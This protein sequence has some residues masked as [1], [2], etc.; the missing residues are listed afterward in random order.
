M[1]PEASNF[2]S[3]AGAAS[4]AGCPSGGKRSNNSP[5]ASTPIRVSARDRGDEP[6]GAGDGRGR[7]AGSEDAGGGIYSSWRALY[8]ELRLLEPLL[9]SHGVWQD[10][11]ECRPPARS[12]R[13]PSSPVWD[14]HSP[15]YISASSRCRVDPQK[16]VA[17]AAA[18]AHV[19][20]V[21]RHQQ[22]QLPVDRRCPLDIRYHLL[23]PKVLKA[24]ALT[25]SAKSH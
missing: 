2:R 21:P 15:T 17:A 18:A 10:R 6:R 12:R 5:G 14:S 7:L 8:G 4:S 9:L 23:V 20:G 3:V 24:A 11:S 19:L 16:A 13:T 25:E 1:V 22:S